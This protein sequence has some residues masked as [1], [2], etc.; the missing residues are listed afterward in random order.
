[1]FSSKLILLVSFAFAAQVSA[2]GVITAVSGA[3]NG[4]T[5]KA[6]AVVDSTPRD[7][8]RRNPFQQDAS[9]IRDEEIADGKAGPCGRTLAGGKT[10]VTAAMAEAES[11]GLPDVGADGTVEMTLHQI[12]GDGAGPYTCGVSTDGTGQSFVDMTVTTNVPGKN[13]RSR[14]KATDFALVA[15]M[16]AG[17]SCTGGSDGQTC[18]IM[19]RNDANAGPF[20][21]CVAV[22]QATADAAAPAAAAG[23]A[24]AA[25]ATAANATAGTTQANVAKKVTRRLNIA[26][27]VQ[28]KMNTRRAT[29]AQLR[30]QAEAAEEEE[31]EA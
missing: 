22:T 20:G 18:L 3:S 12:N 28:M 29:L 25:P 4:N 9:I 2:H 8:S 17:A 7:G 14:A 5:G 26:A 13:S 11:A 23:N 27:E 31:D 21:G 24:T 1:M 6:F 10:D 16:P 19:C 15:K 30:A